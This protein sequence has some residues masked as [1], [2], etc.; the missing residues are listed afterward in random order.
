MGRTPA[1]L[2]GAILWAGT[3]GV[4]ERA[5]PQTEP[6]R[7]LELD[8]SAVDGDRMPVVDLRPEEFEVWIT[9]YRVP[10]ESVSFVTPGAEAGRSVILLLDDVAVPPQ[11]EGR[12]KETARH[13]VTLLGPDDRLGVVRLDGDAMSLTSDPAALRRSVD[14]FHVRSVPRRLEDAGRQVLATIEDLARGFAEE[15]ARRRVIVGIGTGGLLDRPIPSFPGAVRLEREWVDAMRAAARSNVAFYV[16]DPAGL[17]VA[18][19]ADSGR[20]GFARETGGHAFLNTNDLKGAAE[21][22]WREAGTYYVLNV[23]DPP[24]GR[25][26]DLRELDVRV[27][28]KGVTVRSRRGIPP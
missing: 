14:A 28:R 6:S 27:L 3:S 24:V 4:A 25:K 20:S 10:I 8:V 22:I 26:L 21:T 12:V 5:A 19:R 11:L 13:F 2:L 1:V 9:G 23:V 18:P 16:I 17:G 15:P 7:L